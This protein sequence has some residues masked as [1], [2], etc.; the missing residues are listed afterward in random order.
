[1]KMGR[2]TFVLGSVLAG[3]GMFGLMKNPEMS[4]GIYKRL[5]GK[6]VSPALVN[7]LSDGYVPENYQDYI[8][9]DDSIVQKY[10][11]EIE[12]ESSPFVTFPSVYDIKAPPELK[13]EYFSD[14]ELFKKRDHWQKPSEYLRRGAVGDCEDYATWAA[15]DAEA[16]GYEARVIGG[17]I[18]YE[19]DMSL[20]PHWNTEVKLNDE[21]Y[22]MDVDRPKEAVRRDVFG[23]R[24]KRWGGEWKPLIMF[25]KECKLCVYDRWW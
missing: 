15:S 10:A 17:Y 3:L 8:T 18:S 1:M 4:L 24:L 19:W 14:R 2:R 7:L 22:V 13:F 9:P 11:K 6:E 16:K 21:Y 20:S 5:G 25:G 12:Y 23:K